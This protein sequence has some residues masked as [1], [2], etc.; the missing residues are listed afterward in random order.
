MDNQRVV[1]RAALGFKNVQDGLFV[2]GV[3]PESID[4]LG[5][6]AEQPTAPDDVRRSR[7]VFRCR[8]GEIDRVHMEFLLNLRDGFQFSVFARR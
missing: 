6:D 4:R 7:D 5:R 1:L 8:F 2:E 3:G